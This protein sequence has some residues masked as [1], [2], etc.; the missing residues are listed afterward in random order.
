MELPGNGVHDGALEVEALQLHDSSGSC[1]GPLMDMKDAAKY[2]GRSR[3]TF[4][5]EFHRG[6]WTSIEVA[7][8]HPKFSRKQLDKDM[9]SWLKFSQFRRHERKGAA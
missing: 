8:G 9:E 2:T 5:R 4:Q 1:L 6:L 7:G 3:R